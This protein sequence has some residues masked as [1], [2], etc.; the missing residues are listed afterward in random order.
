MDPVLLLVGRDAV[1]GEPA[2]YDAHAGSLS[3]LAEN[4]R[5]L[6]SYIA[7]W[8]Y[9]TG[10]YLILASDT[11]TAVIA[12]L[13]LIGAV[14]PRTIE[15]SER[16]A[17]PILFIELPSRAAAGGDAPAIDTDLSALHEFGLIDPA[18][19][20]RSVLG[21][22]R[23][24]RVQRPNIIVSVTRDAALRSVIEDYR[25]ELE[26]NAQ[27]F[28]MPTTDVDGFAATVL[29]PDDGQFSTLPLLSPESDELRREEQSGPPCGR[30]HGR[31]LSAVGCSTNP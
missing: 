11:D 14:P 9:A 30:T 20:E 7:A 31:S 21:L 1:E 25:R 26:P 8:A 4:A 15:S 24:L 2:D 23:L 18:D 22:A 6:A 27:C 13:S 5:D 19:A 3:E 12:C 10:R 16:P 17:A 28:A 29:H